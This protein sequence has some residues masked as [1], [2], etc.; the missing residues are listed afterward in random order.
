MNECIVRT[1]DIKVAVGY[2]LEKNTEGDQEQQHLGA[3]IDEGA[4][5]Q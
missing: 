1:V 3:N 2:N 5:G 4:R